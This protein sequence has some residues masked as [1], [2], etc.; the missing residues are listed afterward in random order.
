MY[1]REELQ[2]FSTEKL[3]VICRGVKEIGERKRGWAQAYEYDIEV[4]GK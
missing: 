3:G 4:P 1:T 2:G